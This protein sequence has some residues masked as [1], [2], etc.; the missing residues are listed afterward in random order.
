MYRSKS[1]LTI[2]LAG[3]ISY[4][5]T[6]NPRQDYSLPE[7]VSAELAR[8][9]EAYMILDQFA[10]KVWSG[11]NDYL[12]FPFMMTYQNGLRVLIGHPAPPEGFIL[13]PRVKVHGLSVYIDTTKLNDFKIKQ[14]LRCGGGVLGYGSFNNKP[15]TIVD[16]NL[17][18][19]NS[20]DPGENAKYVSAEDHILVFIH[21]LMHCYQEKIMPVSYGNLDLNP[22]LNFAL[23]SEIEGLALIGAFEQNSMEG[24]MPF[25]KDFCIA[26]NYKYRSM[27]PD[28]MN[29]SR[30]DEFREGEAQYS[31]VT[32]LQCLKKG[33]ES[34][35]L[36]GSDPEYHRFENIDQLLDKYIRRLREN[37]GKTLELY[38][39]NYDYGCFEA[40]LL[41]RYF[42]EWQKE[43]E[44]GA[45]LDPVLYKKLAIT[46]S[47]SLASLKRFVDV[48]RIDDLKAKHEKI[49][50]ERN[51][52]YR[53][54][55]SQKGLTYVISFKPIKQ[56]LTDQ[57]DKSKK[58]YKLG[59]NEMYPEGPGNISFDGITLNMTEAPAEVN[60]LYFIKVINTNPK[61]SGKKYSID[62]QSKDAN[63]VFSNVTI[64]TP[65]FTLKAP[66]IKIRER[67]NRIKII[68]LS[69]T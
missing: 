48:Y 2:L 12:N 38:Q 37:C 25:M 6:S 16:L 19:A 65:M 18:N 42:P 7:P 32:I 34:G 1:F 24:S 11:W 13:Y 4:A 10:E 15:V 31:E 54:L 56:Y 5:G 27:N 33:F 17:S 45:W 22:D 69:R 26:R 35:I 59:L 8:L 47:D 9:N 52:T 3:I 14:P 57:V 36:P 39:K 50:N 49:I 29:Q 30:S 68:V 44:S 21:E 60:Q 64:T 23:Y 66:K 62:Y 51:D 46:G 67:A 41:Q 43:I 40:L 61:K 28:E 55:T 63:G 20:K 58:C 53:M